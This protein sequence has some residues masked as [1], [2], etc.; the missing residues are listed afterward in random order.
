MK[1]IEKPN[2]TEWAQDCEKIGTQVRRYVH[3]N[4]HLP[5]D[6][7]RDEWNK[8][9]AAIQAFANKYSMDYSTAESLAG[10]ICDSVNLRLAY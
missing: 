6:T 10:I 5:D 3:A 1:R 8:T 4:A 2:I 9:V 7:I